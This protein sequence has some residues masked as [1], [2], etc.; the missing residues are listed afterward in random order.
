M[1]TLLVEN[2]QVMTSRIA[3][4]LKVVMRVL[5]IEIFVCLLGGEDVIQP[6]GW[7]KERGLVIHPNQLTVIKY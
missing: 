2:K 1:G 4:V 6:E 3:N 5:K 7:R